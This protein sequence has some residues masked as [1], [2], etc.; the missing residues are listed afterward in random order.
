MENTDFILYGLLGL[1]AVLL[2]IAIIILL[3]RN[4]SNR[5][6]EMPN[7]SPSTAEQAEVPQK[8]EEAYRPPEIDPLE[9]YLQH[10]EKVCQS[11]RSL[12]GL[13]K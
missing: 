5:R 2:V 8:S 6:D 13:F 12:V 10:L 7:P 9:K 4:S 11:V 1:V 3:R